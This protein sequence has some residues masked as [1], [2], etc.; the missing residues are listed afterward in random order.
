MNKK[1]FTGKHAA[2]LSF[3]KS[4]PQGGT[5]FEI[6]NQLQFGDIR[7]K[8]SDIRKHHDI[9]DCW[10]PYQYDTGEL[11]EVKRYYYKGAKQ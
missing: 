7:K 8:I 1:Q 6:Q 5:V 4:Q 10:E 9:V 3:L 11:T 2:V